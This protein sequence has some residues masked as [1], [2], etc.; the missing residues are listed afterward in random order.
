VSP[1]TLQNAPTGIDWS[2][3][4]A[5]PSYDPQAQAAEMWNMCARATAQ[6]DAYC[7]QVLQATVDIQLLHGPDY[8]VTVGP[9]SG[10][11][12]LGAYWGTGG[13]NARLILERWPVLQINSVMTCPNNRW[14]RQ[15]STV[16]TGF[17]EPE[18][19]G[20][21]IY[22]ASQPS[23]AASGGQAILVGGGFIDGSLGRN[24]WAI[25]VNYTNGWPHAVTTSSATAGSTSLVVN[26]TTGW[27]V[28]NYYGQYTGATGIIKDSGQ[29]ETIHVSSAST[30]SG[31]GTLSLSTSLVYNHERGILVTTLPASIEKACI[32]IAAAEA[33]T[34]G[35]TSTTIHSIGGHMQSSGN[36]SESLVSEAELLLHPYRRTI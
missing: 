36:E 15:W 27:A 8:Y 11:M 16:P 35:A 32:L 19:P 21:G 23:A 24:G 18:N 31:P 9:G 17:Y 25:Q 12:S 20:I 34:R 5:T 30:S 26:D 29:Q 7:N 6:A 3:I 1:V 22:G 33:L 28:A 14:P 13:G 10:G 2:T 4:P